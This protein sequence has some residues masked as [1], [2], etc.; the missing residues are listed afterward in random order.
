M[1]DLVL[2]VEDD[3]DDLELTL[4]ALRY[5]GFA[6]EVEVARDGEEVLRRLRGP[7]AR[8]DL[9]IL[10]LNIPKLS[11]LEVLERMR[12]DPRLSALSVVVLS[13]SDDPQ[14][15]KK[16]A[17]FGV[18]AFLRKPFGLSEFGAIVEE[19]NAILA[20]VRGERKTNDEKE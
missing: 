6:P 15:K 19:L 7:K 3:P 9:V 4:A 12:K 5:E 13:S 8:P 16:A 17:Q 11:G 10:D 18:H 2:L 14:E 1:R 20:R